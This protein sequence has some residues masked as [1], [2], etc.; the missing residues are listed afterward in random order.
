M[1]LRKFLNPR[2]DKAFKRIFGEERNKDILIHFIND[3]LGYK[4][5]KKIVSVKLL[6]LQ[7]DLEIAA[8]RRSIVDVAC[9]TSD[10]SKLII[11]MQVN[12][13]KSYLKRAEFY[14]ARAY[15]TQLTE[16]QIKDA[17]KEKGDKLSEDKKYALLIPV[18]FIA[19]LNY[20][21]FPKKK[22]LISLHSTRDEATNERDLKAFRYAF[23]ELPKFKKK[24]SECTSIV[25][26][27]CYFLKRAESTTPEELE[28]LVG[29]DSIIR[30]AYD[31]LNI[32]N[33]TTEEFRIYEDIQKVNL[34]NQAAD[35][36][37]FNDGKAEGLV[38]GKAEGLVEGEAK[39]K[40]AVVV[41]MHKKR[42][43]KETIAEI[44]D[45]TVEE[46]EKILAT[47]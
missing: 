45:L 31:E 39:G 35:A 6:P 27:W 33:W 4:G 2:N 37:K 7:Q 24:I 17:E 11:E 3:I 30:R 15:G 28:L 36:C 32:Y 8:V 18:V 34:D 22:A 12:K 46:V 21:E 5:K 25:D 29:K 19:V 42:Q 9:E 16:V 1:P 10:G 26:K 41:R 47:L 14:A 23:V 44:A 38:E 40:R 43:P 20:T 13:H